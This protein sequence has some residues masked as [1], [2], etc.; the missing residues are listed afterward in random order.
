[1]DNININKKRS[2]LEM[3]K[4]LGLDNRLTIG[5]IRTNFI[6]DVKA[7]D[8]TVSDAEDKLVGEF[9]D[10]YVK[11]YSDDSM[12]GKELEVFH[13]RKILPYCYNTDYK[14]MY[15]IKGMRLS[16]NS[17]KANLRELTSDASNLMSETDLRA[18]TVITKELYDGYVEAYKQMQKQYDD[19]VNTK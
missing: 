19:I 15:N 18:C 4:G 3:I 6:A 16:F 10:I 12:F 13:V 5:E 17:I 7:H 2:V 9:K 8:K 1:M 14:R 11:K